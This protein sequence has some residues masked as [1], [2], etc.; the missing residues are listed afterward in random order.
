MIEN[1]NKSILNLIKQMLDLVKNNFFKILQLFFLFVIC[2][3]LF[4]K[5]NDFFFKDIS[6]AVF[7]SNS[8][9]NLNLFTLLT[10]IGYTIFCAL[11]FYIC[12][13]FNL[14]IIKIIDGNHSLYQSCIYVI[15]K[16]TPITI[17]TIL[18]V[19]VIL[20]LAL[21][22]QFVLSLLMDYKHDLIIQ[23]ILSIALIALLLILILVAAKNIFYYFPILLEEKYYFKAIA[24]SIKYTENNVFSIIWKY[25]IIAIFSS[26]I[27]IPLW[28]ITNF[29][30]NFI[31][32]IKSDKFEELI[33]E[34]ISDFIYGQ[35]IIIGSYLMYKIYQLDLPSNFSLTR[36]QSILLTLI[37][38]PVLFV[39]MGILGI[40]F[41]KLK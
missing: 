15:K 27:L 40:A 23:I 12:L 1:Q 14:V 36:K 34:L 11:L 20:S 26:I 30:I 7:D 5:L 9:N 35:F 19:A 39:L 22:V 3:I 33:L 17:T 25:V 24:R 4:I 37:I 2:M 31:V 6:V 18:V 16:S 21:E 13:I 8:S 29:I 32:P 38:L 10:K 41:L 28:F